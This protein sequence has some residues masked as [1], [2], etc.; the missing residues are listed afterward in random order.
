M[1]KVEVEVGERGEWAVSILISD[2]FEHGQQAKY[3]LVVVR[4]FFRSISDTETI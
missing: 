3:R 1:E 2:I 4:F